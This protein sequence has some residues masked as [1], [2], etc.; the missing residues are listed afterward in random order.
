LGSL[1][2]SDF[3]IF[4]RRW[5]GNIKMDP[6]EIVFRGVDWIYLA[7]DRDQCLAAVNMI[8]NILFP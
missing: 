6:F 8:M 2:G 4:R 1:K 3:G 7:Q 5:R